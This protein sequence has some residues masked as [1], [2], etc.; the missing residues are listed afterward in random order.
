M[1]Q[2]VGIQKLDFA[3]KNDRPIRGT[4]VH[5]LCDFEYKDCQGQKADSLFI[6]D[7]VSLPT[8]EI[9]AFYEPKYSF[10][11][12]KYPKLIGLELVI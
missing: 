10:T 12:G 8:L 5:Y 2:L 1:I 11:G 6:G 9:G 3:D 4:K 7:N